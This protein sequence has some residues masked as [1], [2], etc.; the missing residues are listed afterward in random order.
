M[1]NQRAAAPPSA[2][3][4]FLRGPFFFSAKD[5]AAPDLRPLR[6][7]PWYMR[8]KGA[9]EP[10][11]RR[12]SS[13]IATTGTTPM[14][15]DAIDA[16]GE[17][18]ATKVQGQRRSP[19]KENLRSLTLPARSGNVEDSPCTPKLCKQWVTPPQQS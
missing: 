2:G 7:P 3:Y 6:R 9:A 12:S 4:A 11:N 8:C 16:M 13:V 10:R 5:R 14:Y 18:A 15:A 19:Q 17:Q 1:P